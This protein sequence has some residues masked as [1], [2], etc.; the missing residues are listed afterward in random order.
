LVRII[1]KNDAAGLAEPHVEAQ[2]S[3]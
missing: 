2:A 1:G 3:L